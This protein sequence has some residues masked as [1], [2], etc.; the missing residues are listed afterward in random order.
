[1]WFAAVFLSATLLAQNPDFEA[2]GMKALE[3]QK[4][5][6]AIQL[7]TKAVAEDKD[8][9]AALFHL[10]LSN[11]LLGKDAEAIEAYNKTLVL[12][13]GL[14]EAELNLGI[15]LLRQKRA[16]DA[17]KPLE[18]A[19]AKKPKEFR[20]NYFYADALL[21]SGDAAKAQAAFET[22]LAA[23]PDAAEAEWGLGRALAKQNKLVEAAPRFEKAGPPA[24][25]ELAGI[26]EAAGKIAEAIAVYERMP[27]DPA[28]RERLG[29]LLIQ[30]GRPADA[31]PHLEAAVAKSPSAGNMYALATAYVKTKQNEK[32]AKAFEALLAKEPANLE[33]RL[34]HGRL[35][36]DMQNFPGA[37]QEFYRATQIDAA[38]KEA[39]RELA[40]MLNKLGQLPQ[41]LQA[42]DKLGQL[43]EDTPGLNYLRAIMLDK[44]QQ[45]K[46]ALAS[47]EKF[48]SMSENKFPDEEFKSR[49]RI[50]IIKKELSKR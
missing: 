11:S 2:E 32:A 26:Y 14:Y 36:R 5:E 17:L 25:L 9:Y 6:D 27:Q 18:S 8:N 40:A 47:Y 28:V 42:L 3:G 15:V 37:T 38:S 4:Y 50:R 31:I 1:M 10:G 33:L 48:L 20:P 24:I 7:F 19:A 45:Y 29:S 21:Q 46:P 49:Q 16:A 22:A 34:V 41:S 23:K 12:K 39:W 13:P 35:L 44:L 30:A 43:G